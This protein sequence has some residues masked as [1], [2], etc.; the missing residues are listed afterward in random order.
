MQHRLVLKLVIY[1]SYMHM[2]VEL[3]KKMDFQTTYLSCHRYWFFYSQYRYSV[4]GDV[5][6]I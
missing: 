6:P 4:L 3:E 5:Q 1:V 2:R